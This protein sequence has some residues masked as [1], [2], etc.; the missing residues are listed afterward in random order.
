MWPCDWPTQICVTN[1]Y[2]MLW[3]PSLVCK[4]WNVILLSL[5]CCANDVCPTEQFLSSNCDVFRKLVS[6]SITFASIVLRG[7]DIHCFLVLV[8][9]K[10][11]AGC[12]WMAQIHIDMLLFACDLFCFQAVPSGLVRVWLFWACSQFSCF[13]LS[14][15]VLILS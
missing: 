14:Q 9:L 11:N 2:W 13:V 5:L 1:F 3:F 15:I 12:K 7:Q 4:L 6:A 10:L 8:P